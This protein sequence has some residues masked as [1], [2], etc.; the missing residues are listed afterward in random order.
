MVKEV[1]TG[2]GTEIQ[3]RWNRNKHMTLSHKA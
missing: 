3:R 1:D 2:T